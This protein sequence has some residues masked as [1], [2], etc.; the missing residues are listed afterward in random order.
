MKLKAKTELAKK[1][2]K[3]K[4]FIELEDSTYEPIDY[5]LRWCSE[6]NINFKNNFEIIRY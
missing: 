1:I 5:I 2:F 6:T 3:G 4:D